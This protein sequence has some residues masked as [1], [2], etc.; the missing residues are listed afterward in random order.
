M[1]EGM[2][3][4][5]PKAEFAERHGPT[6]LLGVGVVLVLVGL[7]GVFTGHQVVAGAMCTTGVVAIIAA[8]VL[9]RMEGQFK[10]FFLSGSL[11]R[12]S[13]HRKS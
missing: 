5:L 2:A 3:G 9:S 6:V 13:Q 10:V 1:V 7:A 8:A 11:A 4:H 12:S